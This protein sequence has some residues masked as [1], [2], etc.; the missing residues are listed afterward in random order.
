MCQSHGVSF[1]ALQTASEV[2]G[3]QELKYSVFPGWLLSCKVVAVQG[4]V[5]CH[6]LILGTLS[7]KQRQFEKCL[8]AVPACLSIGVLQGPSR[9]LPPSL[10]PSPPATGLS[11]QE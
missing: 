3:R 9:R 7:P 5:E 6:Y 10:P 11:E 4:R 1:S 8:G 2:L